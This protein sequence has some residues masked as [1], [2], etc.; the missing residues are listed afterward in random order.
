M[1]EELAINYGGHNSSLD[2]GVDAVTK[3]TLRAYPFDRASY[4]ADQLVA[5]ADDFA[6]EPLQVPHL[7]QVRVVA[8]G[9]GTGYVIEHTMGLCRDPNLVS[10]SGEEL[11]Q[12][13]PKVL[14]TI[15]EMRVMSGGGDIL[16]VPIDGNASNFCGTTLIDFF[17]PMKRNPDGSFP[18]RSIIH[19]ASLV[20]RRIIPELRGTKSGVMANIMATVH[21]TSPSGIRQTIATPTNWYYD[22]LPLNLNGKVKDKLYEEAKGRFVGRLFRI[23][24][25]VGVCGMRDTFGLP[26]DP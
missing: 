11:Q 17:Y 16:H 24:V 20:R 6:E 7:D 13:L 4:L 23:G 14:A 8:E 26:G 21:G 10:L 12:A 19:S 9:L 15:A 18:M 3:T 2:F 1:A 22:V 5:Y 25:A